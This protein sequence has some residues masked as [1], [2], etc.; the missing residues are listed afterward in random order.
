VI[1]SVAAGIDAQ[2]APPL[3]PAEAVEPEAESDAGAFESD[4][5]G[6]DAFESEEPSAL[7]AA[8]VRN[9]DARSFFAQ[10]EPLKTIA[11]GAKP[12]RIVPSAPHSGQKCGPGSLIPWRMSVRWPQTVQAYS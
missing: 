4:A 3:V 11:G 5:F 9:P 10:P 6:S 12:L 2:S 1:Q 8:F 7:A